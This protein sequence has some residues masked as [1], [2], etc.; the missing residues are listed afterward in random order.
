MNDEEMEIVLKIG[1]RFFEGKLRPQ[2]IGSQVPA[3]AKR[4]NALCF[5]SPT[6]KC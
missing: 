3:H 2:K 1:N 4:L 5:Q 6:P